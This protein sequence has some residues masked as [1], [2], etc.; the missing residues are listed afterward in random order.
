MTETLPQ[1][2]ALSPSL[3]W[4]F[5]FGENLILTGAGDVGWAGSAVDN[6]DHLT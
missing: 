2:S 3:S 5:S 4:V 1:I 6:P